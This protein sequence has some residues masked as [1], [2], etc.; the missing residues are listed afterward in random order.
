[1]R[2]YCGWTIGYRAPEWMGLSRTH[3]TILVIGLRSNEVLVIIGPRLSVN[4]WDRKLLQESNLT[5][6]AAV[7]GAHHVLHPIQANS[8]FTSMCYPL[9]YARGVNLVRSLGSRESGRKNVRFQSKK[10][11]IFRE[12]FQFSRQKFWRPFLF[13]LVVNSKNSLFSLNIHSEL[14]FLSFL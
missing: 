3:I 9:V 4:G 14:I 11:P 8:G 1:M 12:N 10:F 2:S 5:V 7:Q 13:F 6:S